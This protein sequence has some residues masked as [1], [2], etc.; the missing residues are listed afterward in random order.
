MRHSN[1][2]LAAAIMV[3]FWSISWAG[4]PNCLG[5]HREFS[6]AEGIHFRGS[7]SDVEGKGASVGCTSC[8]G[9]SDQHAKNPKLPP[10]QTFD[11]DTA[12]DKACLGCHSGGVLAQWHFSEHSQEPQGCVGC[13]RIHSATDPVQNR[14]TEFGVC[15]SCHKRQASEQIKSSRHPLASGQVRCS[16]CH[17]PHGSGS[18][19]GL[20]ATSV[21][22][23]CYRC[24]AEKRGPFL[25][26][27]EPVQDDCGHCHL[28]HASINDHLL[29][30][31]Q[32]ILCQQCHIASRHPGTLFDSDKLGRRDTN[33]L[34][35]S[36]TNCHSQ[37]HGGNHPAS[38]TFRR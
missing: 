22:E 2:W 17:A 16:D 26:E 6:Q 18:L 27:H 29:K 14:L 31:R 24:H 28:P 1:H 25:Y 30:T 4:D 37:V 10:S 23:T 9:S 15:T 20:A 11:S 13:H 7:G 33:M 19:G 12:S 36:C 3:F 5:C 38:A 21:N 34:G 8:H 35:H 32:P